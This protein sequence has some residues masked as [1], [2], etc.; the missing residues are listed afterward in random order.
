MVLHSLQCGLSEGSKY[1]AIKDRNDRSFHNREEGSSTNVC[2]T[3][4]AS[5][6]FLFPSPSIFVSHPHLLRLPRLKGIHL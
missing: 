4:V 2:P 3:Y 6:V 1:I 5:F